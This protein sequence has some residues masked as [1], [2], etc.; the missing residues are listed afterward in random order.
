M[1]VAHVGAK[2]HQE[3]D[4]NNAHKWSTEENQRHFN[5][6]DRLT[7]IGIIPNQTQH[8]RTVRIATLHHKISESELDDAPAIKRS[9]PRVIRKCV[10]DNAKIFCNTTQ[11]GCVP[12]TFA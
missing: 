9:C 2:D 7:P 10:V 11:R 6:D 12:I 8:L 4:T 5:H 1:R 3:S